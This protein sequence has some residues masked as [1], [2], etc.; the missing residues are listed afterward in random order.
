FGSVGVTA[1]GLDD[2]DVGTSSYSAQRSIIHL[3][4]ALDYISGLRANLGAQ[5]GRIESTVSVLQTSV[6]TTQ[7]ARSRVLDT[8]FAAETA[9]LTR[10]SV[11][12][13]AGVAMVAQA[14]AIPGRVLALLS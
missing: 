12:R 10:A 6:E 14:N 8:D 1:L 3:D 4:V 13:E 11:L 5:L 7:A 2:V 9:A